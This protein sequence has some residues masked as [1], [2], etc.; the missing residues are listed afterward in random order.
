MNIPCKNCIC[1]S[2]CK[3]RVKKISKIIEL[4]CSL[5]EDYVY[6]NEYKMGIRSDEFMCFFGL[7]IYRVLY[8]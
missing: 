1:L 8:Y 7:G 4:N 2:I 5:I 6:N 3:L